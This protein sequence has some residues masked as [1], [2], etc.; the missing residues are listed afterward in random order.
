MP[1]IH[2][3]TLIRAPVELCF[4][5]A[6]SVDV[7]MASTKPS[8]ERAVAGVTSGMMKLGDTVTWEAVHFG[9]RQR[10]TSMIT[11]YERPQV[12][13][14]EMQRGAFKKWHHTHLF[15]ARGDTTLMVDHVRYASPLGLLGRIADQLF[16]EDYMTRLLTARNKY[17]KELAEKQ[18]IG[19]TRTRVSASLPTSGLAGEMK[20]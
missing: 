13:T 7:H 8:R 18:V 3:E 19:E 16:L 12:F 11:V 15:E 20:Q 4:D 9:V 5:L 14:D 1:I 6:R 10:L 2:L 17:I